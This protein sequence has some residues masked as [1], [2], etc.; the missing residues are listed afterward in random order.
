MNTPTRLPGDLLGTPK[1]VLRYPTDP[2]AIDLLLPPGLERCGDPVV[3][4]G[5]Y[6]VP[7]H[8]EPELGVSTK[9]PAAHDGQ[10]GGY[11]LGIGID[12]ESA[13]FISRETNGQPK[14]PCDVRYHRLG[15]AV[16]ASCAHQGTTFLSY[17]GQLGAVVDGGNAERT[18]TEWW[19]KYSR[20]VGGAEGD[21]DLPPR[22][23]RVETTSQLLSTIPVD[24]ELSLR[25]S[26]WDPYTDLLPIRGEVVAELV[27]TKV[28]GRTIEVAGALDPAAFWPFTDTIGGS[29]WPG[30]R[31]APRVD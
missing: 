19:V 30:L 12:Q 4:I 14:F 7:V 24:G 23:V 18:E 5:I 11:T 6:C 31:G 16:H 17:D 9:I 27:A 25:P 29:R 3:S 2:A 28:T 1:L 15:D 20:A 26:R 21:Y 22:V 13:I 10:E 8:G